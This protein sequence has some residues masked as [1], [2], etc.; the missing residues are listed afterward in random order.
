MEPIHTGLYGRKPVS[1]VKMAVATCMEWHASN[2]KLQGGTEPKTPPLPIRT[3]THPNV[4]T[5]G[6][7]NSVNLPFPYFPRMV[8]PNYTK[9]Y[10][11]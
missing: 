2:T 3:A 1:V 11:M 4:K 10:G 8:E 5:V 9:L 6:A 7:K